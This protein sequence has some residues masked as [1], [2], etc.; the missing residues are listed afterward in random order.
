MIQVIPAILEERL[1]DI[2]QK[3]ERIRP[4][5]DIIQLDVMDGEFVPNE[6]F[7]RS[8]RLLADLPITM[9]VHLMIERPSLFLRQ[10]ALPNVKRLI[11]HEEAVS[12]MAECMHIVRDAGKEFAVAINPET[13]TFVLKEYINELDMVLIMGVNPGF[14]GQQFQKDVLEKIKE[15]KHMRPDVL[16]EVDGGVSVENRDMIVEAGVD[17][18][19]AATAIWKSPDIGKT[20]AELRGANPSA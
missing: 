16:V 12:N 9:E 6:T 10:W 13:S 1:D 20:I 19:A 3:V 5:T 15:V 11:V 18:L 17:I 2:K 8:P 7:Y 4:Y 14:S